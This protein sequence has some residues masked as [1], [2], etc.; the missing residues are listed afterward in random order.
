MLRAVAP[1]AS[2]GGRRLWRRWRPDLSPPALDAAQQ[3]LA[4]KVLQQE[5]QRL[6]ELG[7]VRRGEIAVPLDD[8]RSVHDIVAVYEGAPGGRLLLTGEPGSG[9]T[10]AV[11]ELVLGLLERRQS[12]GQHTRRSRY[13]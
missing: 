5:L 10:V 8:G 13:G 2:A 7:V 1:A 4:E 9:K 11:L 6:A 12:T 3:I